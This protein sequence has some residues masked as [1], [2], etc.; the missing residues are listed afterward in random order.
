MAELHA[1]LPQ[2]LCERLDVSISEDLLTEAL[3]HRSYAYEHG[4]L[5]PNERLE[6][7]GDAVLGIVIT[8]ALFSRNP[9]LPEGRLAK[10]RAAIVNAKALAD[11]ARRIELGSYLRLGKGENATGGREK[12]SILADALEALIGAVYL[13][14]GL[15]EA[16]RVIADL[17]GALLDETEGLDA[18]LDWKTSL[19]ELTSHLGLGVP[20]YLVSESGPDHDKHFK[21]RVKLTDGVHGFGEGGT[22]KEAE[23]HAARTT[24][25]EISGTVAGA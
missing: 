6:F 7:L 9:D 15:P 17:M 22:K 12:T 8:D 20:Q 24:F 11:I 19:Q 23:Q 5:R 2:A 1:S 3:T 25:A 4:G 21:A 14:A 10:M 13:S 16:T 18:E